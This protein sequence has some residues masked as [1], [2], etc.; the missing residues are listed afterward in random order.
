MAARDGYG[1][2]LGSGYLPVWEHH[3]QP[4]VRQ[5]GG[6]H[7][8]KYRPDAR[9]A[10]TMRETLASSLVWTAG[11]SEIRSTRLRLVSAMAVVLIRSRALVRGRPYVAQR[12]TLQG[13]GDMDVARQP[14]PLGHNQMQRDNRDVR[15]PFAFEGWAARDTT[16]AAPQISEG[17][18][19]H[20]C[21]ECRDS[22]VHRMSPHVGGREAH[23]VAERGARRES[24]AGY[25]VN[26]G[27]G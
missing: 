18:P 12:A 3:P 4:I 25:P 15:S 7:Q 10:R 13:T 26:N 1:V 5:R 2:K 9:S 19:S 11:L 16:L 23:E 22:C 27:P 21:C 17:H 8:V 6:G 24:A 20:L 14:I